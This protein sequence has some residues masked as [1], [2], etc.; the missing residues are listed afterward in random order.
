MRTLA[1]LFVLLLCSCEKGDHPLDKQPE[2][3][4]VNAKYFIKWNYPYATGVNLHANARLVYNNNKPIMR[5][6]SYLPVWGGYDPN[7]YTDQIFDT[8]TEVNSQKLLLQ[9]INKLQTGP[10]NQPRWEIEMVDK[11]PVKRISYIYNAGS[12]LPADTVIYYYDLNKQVQRVESHSTVQGVSYLMVKTFFFTDGNLQK[13]DGIYIK[14]PNTVQYFT[15][16]TFSSYDTK[17]NTLKAL[18]LWDDLYYR[19]VSANNFAAYTYKKL[20]TQSNLID[21]AEIS[22]NLRYDAEGNITFER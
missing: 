21:A 4:V 19:S 18:W 17:P 2:V 20:D 3:E 9:S 6:G 12:Y 16:E 5:S 8:V 15:V 11:R 10:I 14:K 7:A 1:F 13:I 22:W